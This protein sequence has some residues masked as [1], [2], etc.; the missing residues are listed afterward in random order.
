MPSSR[1]ARL[2]HSRASSQE[3]CSPFWPKSTGPCESA[4]SVARKYKSESST[5][6]PSI[7]ILSWSRPSTTALVSND[8]AN[9]G[10]LVKTAADEKA[11][12]IVLMMLGDIESATAED[13]R[14]RTRLVIGML[15]AE[16]PA[17][18]IDED[19]LVRGVESALNVWVPGHIAIEDQRGHVEW[20]TGKRPDI[21]W[22]FWER[23]RRY[24]EEVQ[25]WAPQTIRRLHEITDD[26]LA[27]L[28]DPARDGPWDRRGM[29]VGHVQSGKT[30]N[31]TGLICKAADAGYKLIVILAGL[32]D[33]LRSQT[34]L[35]LDEG[36]LGWDTQKRMLFDQQNV[37]IGVGALRGSGFFH[38]NSLTSSAQKGDFS[39]RIAEQAGILPGG[40]DPVLLVV[41]KNRSILEN[42][43]KWATEVQ[44]ELDPASGL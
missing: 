22:R 2:V 33:N 4:V 32:N 38:V 6:S 13:I 15:K 21:E 34:Q 7:G 30:S 23:Y 24:L 11:K 19:R 41:K 36:F 1:R 10:G 27:K 3:R 35:R 25:D 42:V 40:H 37:R 26:V 20:L 31:Y 44:G 8:T 29:L 9:Y 14:S 18:V 16:D 5:W 39:K 12:R 17:L 28:E 43:I